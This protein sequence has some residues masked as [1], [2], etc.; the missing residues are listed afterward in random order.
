MA[1][2]SALKELTEAEKT[3]PEDKNKDGVVEPDESSEIQSAS[4]IMR[5]AKLH[6]QSVEKLND[7]IRKD[8]AKYT[9]K[10]ER[11]IASEFGSQT[12]MLELNA[13]KAAQIQ[14]FLNKL[15]EIVLAK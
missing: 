11:Y 5:K 6:S 14:A 1:A 3:K 7:T 10:I 2:L 13:E 9:E 15:H 8:I 12:Q 4:D